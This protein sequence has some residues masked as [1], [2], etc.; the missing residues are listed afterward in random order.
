MTYPGP[1]TGPSV[2]YGDVT[3]S[4]GTDPVPLFGPPT[5]VG[6]DL[7]FDPITFTASAAGGG[8]DVTD[9]QLNYP[10]IT[11]GAPALTKISINEGGDYTLSEMGLG[12]SVKY[13]VS[14]R[15]T[16]L[17]IDGVAVATPFD[18]HKSTSSSKVLPPDA[19]VLLSW[20]LSLNFPLGTALVNAGVSYVDGI[21]KAEVVVN[22]QL[23]AFS[24]PVSLAFI[25]KKNFVIDT[26][27]DPADQFEIPEPTSMV[28]VLGAIFGLGLKRNR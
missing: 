4:S 20:S 9:G 17:E 22:D 18:L 27:T 1:F 14:V 12:T 8:I 11:N 23:A 24:Q 28:L 19:G 10:V 21:T 2:Q 15:V 6:D 16:V 26:S 5:L 3:E 13:G 25:A 7:D